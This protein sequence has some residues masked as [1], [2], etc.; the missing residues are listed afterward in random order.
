MKALIAVSLL[1]FVTKANAFNGCGEYLL[2]G[3]LEKEPN[4][5]F[6]VVYVINKGT[7]DEIVM[8]FTQEKDFYKVASYLDRT[9]AIRATILNSF[10]GT[11]GKISEVIDINRRFSNTL[12]PTNE[13]LEKLKPLN[14]F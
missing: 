5:R 12:S 14:C 11:K 1:V 13:G 6:R 10:D 4:T 3:V 2:K 8:D 7:R 9:S